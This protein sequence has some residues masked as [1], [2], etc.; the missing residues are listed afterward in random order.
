LDLRAGTLNAAVGYGHPQVVEAI[1]DQATKLMTWDLGEATTIPAARLAARI[2]ELAPGDLARTL[3]CNSGSEAVEAAVKI[4]RGWHALSGRSERT[5]VLSLRDG[6]H[7]STAAGIAATG[8]PFRRT[9]A[10]PLPSGYA[11]I[12]TPRCPECGAGVAHW[13]CQVPGA[14]EL[15]SAIE[16]HGPERV[17]AFLVEP[18]LGVGGVIVPPKGYLRAVREVCTR[19]G[20][21][22][23]A[24][25]VVTGFG[26]TGCWFGCDHEGVVPDILVTAKH[27][28]GAY[29]PLAAVTVPDAI[30]TTF[31]QDPFLGGL[32]HGHTT[33][34]HAVACA[35]ALAV[36]DVITSGR[37]VEHCAAVGQR[38]AAKLEDARGIA[39]V[40]DVRG[41]GLLLGVEFESVELAGAVAA[42]AQDA[43][44]LVRSF[45]TVLTI[46]PPLVITADEAERGVQTVLDACASVA[47]GH[48]VRP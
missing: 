32:R 7:G 18:V 19:H 47:A 38:L 20:V 23:I 14:E 25:E 1:T 43:G 29:A 16:R 9:N 41:R 10:G 42:V 24:D 30:F 5:W 6:Y 34:G 33:G 31:A 37:L 40:R 2:A 15:E 22:L 8:S 48:G 39:G 36:L 21:L 11:Q 12:A 28:A 3:F 27:L 26:R 13:A 35:A 44:V 45:G 46:A 17:A 4:A